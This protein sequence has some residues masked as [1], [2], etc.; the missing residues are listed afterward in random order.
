MDDIYKW[1]LALL[2]L[3]NISFQFTDTSEEDKKQIKGKQRET[4]D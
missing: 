1:I 2:T 3:I 4:R